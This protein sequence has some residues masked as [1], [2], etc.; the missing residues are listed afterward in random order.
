MPLWK[1]YRTIEEA[2]AERERFALERLREAD[3]E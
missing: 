1:C 3:A 2:E